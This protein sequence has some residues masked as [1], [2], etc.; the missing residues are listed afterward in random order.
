MAS[1]EQT[2]SKLLVLYLKIIFIYMPV[3]IRPVFSEET[4][5]RIF[6]FLLCALA[7]F[8]PLSRFGMSF[9]QI[10]MGVNW[11]MEGNYREKTRRFLACKPAMVFM[12]IYMVH[13]VG[14]L[15][16]EDLAYGVFYDLKDKLP[17]LTL[18][19][20]VASYKPLNARQAHIL[21]Y[22]FITAVFIASLI[23][24]H[25]YI[26][27]S[28]INFRDM[29]PFMLHIYVGMM[30]CMAAFLLPW[31]TFRITK[32]FQWRL[33]SVLIAFWLLVFLFVLRTMTGILSLGGIILFFILRILIGRYNIWLRITTG[34]VVLSVTAVLTIFTIHM[35]RMINQR[36]VPPEESLYEQT[37]YGNDYVH[38]F[39]ANHREN[40]HFVYLFVAEQELR[41]AWN[42]QSE[43]DFDGED[44]RENPLHSTLYRYLSSLGFRKDRQG[45]E[46]LSE[47]DIDAIERGVPNHL[48]LKWP[49]AVVRFHETLW[50]INWYLETGNPSGHSFTQRIDLW[51]ASWE[52]FKVKPW[53]G[54]GTGDLY[55]AMDY[56]LSHIGSH[57]D[58]Y[59]W[60]PHNQFLLFLVTLG[61]AGSVVIWLS[62]Y[63]FIRM[64]AAWKFLPFNLFLII[65][66]ISM[67]ANH[68]ID[69]QSG[70][71]FFAFFT[72]FFGIIYRRIYPDTTQQPKG[73]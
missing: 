26:S 29:S 46:K 58:T 12:V 30:L 27:D 6:F 70:Q 28:Y 72:V 21:L 2:V 51:K 1:E 5:H 53:F 13:I 48:Y 35:Y 20:L 71:T 15:W 10:L 65:L 59:R 7:L 14:L 8:M 37:A 68:T 4:H 41:Q 60:K 57:L 44:M 34:I 33:T 31:L 39:E 23:G 40:G 11:L 45:L 22:V 56:G 66:I 73:A 61:I 62:Y 49:G 63:I 52:A 32:E 50:E 38:D 69:S 42:E 64:T 47:E 17:M 67:L 3:T 16:S 54:W 18:P 36:I 25:I 43:F 9:T 19:F 55:I 24:L